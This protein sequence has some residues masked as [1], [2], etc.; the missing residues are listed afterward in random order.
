MGL[1]LAQLG[2]FSFL[3]LLEGYRGG[4][5]DAENYHR[6]LFIAL[7]TLVVTPMLLRFGA[8]FLQSGE[9]RR[10]AVELAAHE[11]ER[12]RVLIVGAGP[13]GRDVA[14]FLETSG[15]RVAMIDLSP[16]NL[17][18]FAQQGFDTAIGDAR[19]SETLDHAAIGR[20]HLAI[21]CVPNDEITAQVTTAIRR[22]NPQCAV[23]ARVRYLLN[24]ASARRAGA[25]EV[26]CEE[27]EAARAILASVQRLVDAV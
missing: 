25:A 5:I 27:A 19:E 2:E 17:Q 10:P 3:L 13:I 18:P 16:V 11:G 9:R 26:I 7:G 24:V 12:K 22:A 8:R 6:T 23:I 21:V 14:A 20:T 1:G 15:W 4:V